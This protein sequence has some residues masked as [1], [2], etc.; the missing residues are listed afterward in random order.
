V[1]DV[2]SARLAV[3]LLGAVELSVDGS[4][5]DLGGAQPRAIVAH[6]ALDADRVVSVER[7][8]D[9]LWGDDPPRTPLG[10]LQSY[11]SRLRRVLE[12][13]RPAGAASSRLLSEAPGYRLRVDPDDV[14]A[15]R[16]TR[17]AGDARRAIDG[18]D[19]VTAIDLADAALALWRGDPLA[20]I[21]PDEQVRPLVVPLVERHDTVVED[22][23]DSLLAIGRHRD[24]LPGLQA[25]VDD[26]PLR[27]R[28]WGLL[29]LALY[30]SGRQADALRALATVRDRLVDELGL[31]LGPELRELERGILGHDPALL[32]IAPQRRVDVTAAPP[33]PPPGSDDDAPQPPRPRPLVGRRSE[34][35]DLAAAFDRAERG[36]SQLV[37]VEGEP[38]IGKST[39]AD[40]AIAHAR[41]RGWRTATGRCVEAG[42]APTLWPALEIVRSLVDA[43]DLAPGLEHDP[44][45]RLAT[46]PQRP[47]TAPTSVEL[48]DLFVNLIDGL[49]PDPLLPVPLLIVVD[50]LHWADEATLDVLA[51]AAARLG[52]R[53]VV[54]LAAF[55]PP[56]LVPESLLVD[57]LGRLRRLP[58]LTVIVMPPLGVG[59]VGELM[60]LTAGTSPDEGTAARVHE[61]TG[62]NPLFVT[63]L[64]RLVGERSVAEV[65]VP[66]AIRD[67]VR[68]RLNRL[69]PRATAELE[70]AAVI[71]ERFP[72]RIVLAASARSPDSCLDALDAAIVTRILVPDGDDYRFAHALVRDAVLADLTP[73]RRQR[74]HAAVADAIAETAGI[75][76]DTVE[77]IAH[78]RLAARSILDPVEVA[79]ALVQASDVARW[80]HALDES[81]RLAETA[82]ELLDGV[83]RDRTASRVEVGAVES[84][85]SIAYRRGVDDVE[86]L[87]QR[88]ERIA[89]RSKCESTAALAV[90]LRFG[91]IDEVEHLS[92]MAA[93]VDTARDLARRCREPYA[94]VTVH[95]LLASWELLQGNLAA[96]KQHADVA[97]AASGSASPDDPPDH[98]PLVLMPLIAGITAALLGDVDDARAQ[99]GRRLRAWLAQRS[100]VDA[101]AE[102]NLLFAAQFVEAVLGEPER[103]AALG[104]AYRPVGRAGLFPEQD[105]LVA[106]FTSWGETLTSGAH[107]PAPAA[108]ALA[109]VEGGVN[110][111]LVAAARAFVGEC[112]LRHGDAEAVAVLARARDEALD[113]GE[114][115]WLAE[116]V[117]LQAV[118][119]RRFDGGRRTAA[120]LDE[121]AL[122]AERQGSA[123]LSARIAAT[124]AGR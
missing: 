90:F 43:D 114:V 72:L 57:A 33:A 63:E 76:P 29:A 99:V 35:A 32:R 106:L 73:V 100:E 91:E 22:R 39:L 111:V 96:A 119:D 4:P 89:A 123:L 56:D 87:A 121:A 64:A 75:G 53:P 124:R 6:L 113:R 107:D 31:E 103:A 37:L 59:E 68:E 60:E 41:H 28:R 108:E 10:T 67:V 17:L 48:V 66:A 47:A 81:E 42:L 11:I 70:L 78:H 40:A 88:V 16:F 109:T 79:D 18:G 8:V 7:L 69:P 65:A 61:R 85:I 118:A 3:R 13:E 15:H 74:L 55:R 71:G 24:A 62:G 34:W 82:L 21:G 112:L 9:R 58:G 93:I 98:V 1:A 83:R 27:E 104:A 12:P 84:V 26:A 52:A 115:W 77:P 49:G 30:R 38:G 46:A 2:G 25:A 92:D 23:F 117:R 95:Y 122:V 102:Q 14:D 86:A 97:I 51:L 120:L 105:A 94:M 20:G 36:A 45:V 101:T 44:L 50:D 80:K 19:H 54:V 110:L 5:V 116:I